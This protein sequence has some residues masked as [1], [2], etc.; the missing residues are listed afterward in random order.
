MLTVVHGAV[1][2]FG[3]KASLFFSDVSSYARININIYWYSYPKLNNF[4]V[5]IDKNDELKTRIQ[6][7]RC[8]LILYHAHYS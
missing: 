5:S 2:D 1:V 4:F 8:S 7:E 6:S 3:T